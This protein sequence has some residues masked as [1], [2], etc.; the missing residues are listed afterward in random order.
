MNVVIVNQQEAAVSNLGIEIIKSMRGCFTPDE[1]IGTFSNF[2]FLRMIIDVT[3]LQN[4]EDPVTYQKLSIGLPVDKIILLIPPTSQLTN[5][6]FLSKL[7]SMG[8]YNFTT[9]SDGIRY[10][11]ATP[12]TYRDVAHLHQIEAPQP[13]LPQAGAQQQSNGKMNDSSLSLPTIRILGV[14]NVTDGAGSSS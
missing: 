3:A 2:Y 8:Y 7:I 10:L 11:L 1:L 6:M 14:K 5:S 9:N 13:V 4:F 12:N